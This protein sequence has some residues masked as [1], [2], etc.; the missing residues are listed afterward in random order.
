MQDHFCFEVYFNN[1][2]LVFEVL[3]GLWGDCNFNSVH[4]DKESQDYKVSA[5]NILFKVIKNI[6]NKVVL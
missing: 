6:S 2:W 3:R 4:F 5:L 1:L